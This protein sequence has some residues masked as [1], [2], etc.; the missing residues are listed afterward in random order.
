MIEG[1]GD[2]RY[3][4]GHIRADFSS[5]V[6]AGIDHTALRVHLAAHLT[7]IGRYPEPEPYT[8][9]RELAAHLGLDPAQV[10][11]TNG[12]TEAIYLAAHLM[13]RQGGR[14]AIVEPTFAEY[15]DA[16]RIHGLEPE[17][18]RDPFIPATGYS[19]LWCCNPNNPTGRIW[20]RARLLAAIDARPETIFVIDQSYEAF[21]LKPV[22]S[23]V[24]AAARP[25]VI[26]IHSMT[27]CYAVPGL[28]LGYLTASAALCERLRRLRM[29]WSVNV[30]AIEA[31][32]FLLR[33]GVGGFSLEAML[34]E[35][36]RLTEALRTMGVFRPLPTDTHFFLV[37]TE[38]STA[39]EIKEWLAREEGILIR[40][41]DNFHSLT[42]R[43]FRIAAQTHADNDLLIAALKRWIG[44]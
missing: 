28:R 3:K 27:K 9:E 35:A 36:E 25:N 6:P 12:A 37:E 26:L 40:N 19:S 7:D 14:S 4:Y 15:A 41:A 38:Y 43:H 18:V 42:P 5:N 8:L 30:L 20:E 44:R 29:P 23:T 34:T 1:H 13:A 33:E 2:D 32:R 17:P 31:G 39:A 24:E 16:C 10:V 21:T 11:A 22:L